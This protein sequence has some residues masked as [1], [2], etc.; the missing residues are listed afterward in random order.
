MGTELKRYVLVAFCRE[1]GDKHIW[2]NTKQQ[3][4]WGKGGLHVVK[5]PKLYINYN[6][7]KREINHLMNVSGWGDLFVNYQI[8]EVEIISKGKVEV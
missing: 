2:V 7:A 5:H 1:E 3:F 8:H 4:G 6:R